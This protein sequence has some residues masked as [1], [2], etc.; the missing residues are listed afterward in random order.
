[1]I[2]TQPMITAV[3]VEEEQAV[4]VP[5]QDLREEQ[6]EEQV[7]RDLTVPGQGMA[8]TEITVP[9]GL[10]AEVAEVA[11]TEPQAAPADQVKILEL[12]DQL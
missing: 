3:A 1:M 2:P 6:L 8:A 10:T 11:A 5:Q 9:P 4:Q 12:R 7:D